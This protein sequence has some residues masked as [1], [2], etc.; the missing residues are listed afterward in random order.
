MLDR[1]DTWIVNIKSE[2][3]KLGLSYIWKMNYVDKST[4]NVIKNRYY[5]IYKQEMMSDV[6]NIS[7]GE[8]Y[9]HL[10]DNFCIQYYLTKPLLP[11]YRQHIH[12]NTNENFVA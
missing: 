4:F 1:K 7:R 11:V 8:V 9:K 10:I 12:C 3:D 6:Q 2:I 5:D